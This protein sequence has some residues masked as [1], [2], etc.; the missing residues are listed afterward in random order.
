MTHLHK[1]GDKSGF[2]IERYRPKKVI[3]VKNMV[4]WF[5]VYTDSIDSLLSKYAFEKTP[6]NLPHATT[7]HEVK[8][9]VHVKPQRPAAQHDRYCI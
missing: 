9:A 7:V 1:M 6:L 2:Y 5:F 8:S 3:G 4:L